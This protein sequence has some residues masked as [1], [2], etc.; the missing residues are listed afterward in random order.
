MKRTKK[1]K[2]TRKKLIPSNHLTAMERTMESKENKNKL[3]N[4]K[5]QQINRTWRL[6]TCM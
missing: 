1:Q 4:N 6:F 2:K 5:Q 3:N